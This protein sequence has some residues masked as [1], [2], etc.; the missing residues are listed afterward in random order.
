[1][2]SGRAQF[3]GIVLCCA[4]LNATP[5]FA[6]CSFDSPSSA[7]RLNTSLVRAYATCAG[8]TVPTPNTS[9][10]AGVPACGPPLA[11]SEFEFGPDGA[12]S[13]L[14]KTRHEEPCADGSGTSCM[15][16]SLRVRCEGVLNPG[17]GLTNA[18]GWS[19]RLITRRTVSDPAS[20][21][22]TQLDIPSTLVFEQARNGAFRLRA[23]AFDG[24]CPFLAC[25]ALPGCT[26]L[27]I[28]SAAIADPTGRVFAVPG[29]S[30]R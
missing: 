29:S 16:P 6:Q 10:M 23:D 15:K 24:A 21:D 22:M 14:I 17:G 18:P 8:I 2:G 26:N 27:Q 7:K 11:L 12:C 25:P 19:L 1:M 20:G 5:L 3:G 28:V 13:L 30:S 9:T 4:L